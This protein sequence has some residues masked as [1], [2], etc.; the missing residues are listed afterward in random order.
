MLK[1]ILMIVFC[2]SLSNLQANESQENQPQNGRYQI[3]AALDRYSREV[4]VIDT[5]NG[6]AWVASNDLWGNITSWIELPPLPV[7]EN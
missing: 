4:Y 3:S 1:S 7:V 5:Q 6:K 2:L